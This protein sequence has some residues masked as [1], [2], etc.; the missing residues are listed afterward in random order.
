MNKSNVTIKIHIEHNNFNFNCHITEIIKI[1]KN[2]RGFLCRIKRLPLILYKIQYY[3]KKCKFNFSS[4][5]IDGRINSCMDEYVIIELLKKKFNDKIKIPDKIRKWY[6]IL[7]YDELYGWLPT[8]IKTTTTLTCDNTGNLAMCVYSYTNEKLNI[9]KSY[10]N[11]E[12][13]KILLEKIKNK[14]YNKIHKKD[15]YFIVLNKTNHTDIIINS[16]K[17]LSQLVPNINNLPFQIKWNNNREYNYDS[18]DNKIKLFMNCI[19]KPKLSWKETFLL[20][21]RTIN[22]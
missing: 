20:N 16:I 4:Q 5:T 9:F 12:M 8:N 21:I 3:L 14:K 22:V 17:G 18:I 7:I 1:Q 2:I 13:S 19:K 6:D 11:G 15:Y 10:N